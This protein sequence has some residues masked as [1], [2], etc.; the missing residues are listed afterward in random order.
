MIHLDNATKLEGDAWCLHRIKKFYFCCNCQG[1]ASP[2]DNIAVG[3]DCY[4]T[5]LTCIL[6]HLAIEF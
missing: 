6:V 3:N 1:M 4:I 2:K 5:A